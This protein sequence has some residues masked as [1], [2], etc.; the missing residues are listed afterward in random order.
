MIGIALAIAAIFI[1]LGLPRL[2]AIGGIGILIVGLG[3][4]VDDSAIG[5]TGLVVCTLAT[6]I[7]VFDAIA[8]FMGG[9]SIL[10]C[11]LT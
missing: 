3:L 11:P 10:G 5:L 6:T 4:L 9:S 2:D 7:G 8:L 1:M